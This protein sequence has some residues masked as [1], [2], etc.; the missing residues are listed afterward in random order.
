M[1]KI[2]GFTA[3]YSF[4]ENKHKYLLIS[5]FSDPSS[6][7]RVTPQMDTGNPNQLFVCYW[8]EG[9]GLFCWYQ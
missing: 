6:N 3:D 8:F 2:P 9:Y 7:K 4:Y 5:S 1:N